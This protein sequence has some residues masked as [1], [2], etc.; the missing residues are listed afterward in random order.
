MKTRNFTMSISLLILLALALLALLAWLFGPALTGQLMAWQ[1]TQRLQAAGAD[2]RHLNPPLQK[3]TFDDTL[4]PA[5]AFSVINGAGQVG[6]GPAFHNTRLT[7]DHGLTITQA[8][9]PDFEHESPKPGQPASQRYN[10]ATLI[11]FQG[12]QP[13]PGEDVVFQ[14]RM[15]V[16]PEFYGSAGFMVQ[17]QGT[18]LSDGSF[19]GR[20]KN[21]AFTLFGIAFMGPESSLFG[22][23]GATVQRVVNWW[24][25]LVWP[26]AMDMH[27]LHTYQLRLH[28]VD[29]RTWSGITSVDGQV[30]SELSLPP[31]GPLE[32]HIWG[33]NYRLGTAFTGTP[34]I[35]FQNGPTKWVRFEE[36]SAW[37]EAVQP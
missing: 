16:S 10:N 9:D 30:L 20:F 28:W 27:T 32:V 19:Q 21:Q 34:E 36:V 6:P 3:E 26:L 12:Y 31:L 14:A 18:I 11:G 24:P 4:S 1:E 2:P 23:S 25:E 22:K 15:Q 37:A 35:G 17:P 5:W 29:A 13:T 8:F 7:L 33:D